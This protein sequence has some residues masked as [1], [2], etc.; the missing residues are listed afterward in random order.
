M[1]DI[2]RHHLCR[3]TLIRAGAATCLSGLGTGL[4]A[5]SAATA[6][7]APPPT[8]P[9]L[10]GQ[11]TDNSQQNARLDARNTAANQLTVGV[12]I[13]GQGP[14]QF[15]VDTA[16]EQSVISAEL[17]LSLAL[18]AGR[19]VVVKG[20]N[21]LIPA[22]TARVNRLTLG[23]FVH[24][25]MTLPVLPRP[26]MKADGFL[27]LDVINGTRVTFDFRK[28]SLRV[29]APRYAAQ[30]IY[31]PDITRVKAY[32]SAGHLRIN[33]CRVDGVMASAIIDT[34]AEVSIGNSALRD[35]LA[36]RKGKVSDLGEVTLSG[37]TGGEL[38]T[39]LM[40]VSKLRM[41]DLT[42]SDAAITRG[43]L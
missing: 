6:P 1:S 35:A 40:G 22:P 17:A 10:V 24:R 21:G 14:Y 25:N 4:P 38:T 31:A 42:F 27:G 19:N 7:A 2:I 8:M 34:G 37:V 30:R 26:L 18:P 32:G 33:D 3:R 11:P 28:R 43:N 41:Q 23:S 16:A 20:I 36:A 39:R 12:L 5:L 15:V 13:N 29:E 9:P